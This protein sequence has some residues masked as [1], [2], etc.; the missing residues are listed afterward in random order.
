M[1]ALIPI[2]LPIC[3]VFLLRGERPIL[4]DTGRSQDAARVEAGLRRHG[5][6]L[7]DLTLILHTHAH[8]DHCGSTDELRR[9]TDAGIAVHRADAPLLQEGHNGR[10]VGATFSGLLFRR[11]LDR[12]YPGTTPTVIFDREFDLAP[13]GVAAKAVPTPGHTAGS[14]SVITADGD[15]IVGDLLMGGCLGGRVWSRRPGDH[16]FATDRGAVRESIHALLALSPRCIYPAHGGPLT[17]DA[18]RRWLGR[19]TN[20]GST[21]AARGMIGVKT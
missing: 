1:A 5:V 21:E 3:N 7:A 4:I 9:R 6:E 11:L 19:A 20:M 18:V 14:I 13:Y 2:P 15:A 16:Y 10:L 17:P 8:W 12:R